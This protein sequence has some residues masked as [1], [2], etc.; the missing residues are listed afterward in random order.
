MRRWRVQVLFE[1]QGKEAQHSVL[2]Y[3]DNQAE[4]LP[5]WDIAQLA[6]RSTVN[7]NVAGSIPAVPAT[8]GDVIT[9]EE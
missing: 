9:K 5:Q 6:E 4:T 7:R 8:L 1:A 2:K 3:W